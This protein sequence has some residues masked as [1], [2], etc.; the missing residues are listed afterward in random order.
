MLKT[1]VKASSITNLTDARYFAAWEVEWLG[2][3]FDQNAENAILPQSMKAIREWVDGVKI[4]G[5]FSNPTEAD[6]LEAIDFLKLDAVQCTPFT[7]AVMLADLS[8]SIP[9]IQEIIVEPSQ[10]A[11]E[12]KENMASYQGLVQY[13][14]LDFEKN[15]IHFDAILKGNF[16]SLNDLSELCETF[17]VLIS[18]DGSAEQLNQM[19]EKVQPAGL[20]FVGGEEEKTGFKSFDQLDEIF[21]SLE[22]LI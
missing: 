16:W 14:L 7:T 6:I 3:N 21:E 12:I 13:Y 11:S 1:K 4:V 19:L 22:I 18:I 2:F 8:I 10:S 5:E 17:P 15:G 20:N 9:I